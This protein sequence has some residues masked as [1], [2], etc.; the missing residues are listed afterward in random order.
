MAA[1][2][3][4]Q[5]RKLGQGGKQV[6]AAVAPGAGLSVGAVQADQEGGAG[7]LLGN[8]AGHNAHHALMPSLVRQ[9]DCLGGRPL[10]QHGNGGRIDVGFNLLTLTVQLAELGRHFPGMA[11]VLGQ[12]QVH[13]QLHLAH[14]A[15]GV[16]PGSQHKAD[17]G[18]ADG[19]FIAATF[20]DQGGKPRP[21]GGG[22]GLQ[23]PGDKHPVF[24]HQGD[25]IGNGAQA[26]HIRVFVQHRLR[27]SGQG[28]GQLEGNGNAGQISV[29]VAA[30][31]PVGVHHRHGLGQ[32]IL[33]LMV[34]GDDQIHSQLSAQP[35][36]LN[37]GDSA[38]HRNDQG[39][40]LVFQ[41]VQGNGVQA[42]A[43]FQAAGDVADAIGAL[44]AQKVG[45][46]TGGGNAV[47]IVVAEDRDFFTPGNGCR[48]PSRGQ[49]HIRQQIGVRQAAIAVQKAGCLVGGFH[50]PSGQNHGGQGGEPS[51]YQ[52]VYAAYIRFLH[53]PDSVFQI[54]THPIKTFSLHYSKNQS[55]RQ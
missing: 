4:Q 2:A 13:G 32:L 46:Q 12:E 24:S 11:F 47:H 53:I 27:V 48:H 55:F 26:D 39:N 37:G 51:G 14:T 5:G 22:Q 25:Y 1:V 40:T 33:A 16:D 54:H 7:K 52:C 36:F 17:G 30:V 28:A 45:K 8:P 21:L 35:G 42:V 10:R 3:F 50:T 41:L 23:P 31:R 20:P 18:G 9:H 15:G 6:K 43:L 44:L 34:V 29:G 19:L 49:S 38:V